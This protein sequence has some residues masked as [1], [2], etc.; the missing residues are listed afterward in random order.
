MP[1]LVWMPHLGKCASSSN[2]V[3]I[4][5]HIKDTKIYKP[6]RSNYLG[7]KSLEKACHPGLTEKLSILPINSVFLSLFK[8]TFAFL[9]WQ[10]Q[11]TQKI[12]GCTIPLLPTPPGHFLHAARFETL[13]FTCAIFYCFVQAL[14]ILWAFAVIPL[15]LIFPLSLFLPL[16]WLIASS[17]TK[18]IG[19][20]LRPQYP[21]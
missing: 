18:N 9:L 3:I 10:L 6:K 14:M 7:Y 1:W 15:T 2:M 17:H 21:N 11:Q 8:S 16:L 13:I 5:D 20:F 19:Y 4:T 12:T